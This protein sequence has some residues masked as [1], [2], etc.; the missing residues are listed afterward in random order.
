M[1]DPALDPAAAG[2][3]L[4]AD[5]D[6][7]AG[8]TTGT[9]DNRDPFDPSKVDA[10]LLDPEALAGKSESEIA[11]LMGVG[12]YD[13]SVTA[14]PDGDATMHELSRRADEA[15]IAAAAAPAAA[16]PKVE[17]AAVPAAATPAPA[18]ADP[19][20]DAAALA[21]VAAATSGTAAAETFVETR[22]GKGKIPYGVLQAERRETAR[23]REENARL[24]AAPAPGAAPAQV[25]VPT[26][27][28]AASEIEITA[29]DLAL[30]SEDE[31]KGLR[32]KYPEELVTRMV[33]DNKLAVAAYT[34]QVRDVE[35]RRIDA[36]KTVKN[37]VTDFIDSHPV[38]SIWCAGET[39][40]D[41]AAF[42]RAVIQ[43]QV[44]REL[45]EWQG[46]PWQDRMT[47]AAK[48]TA[49]ILGVAYPGQSPAPT[50]GPQLSLAERANAALAAAA[51]TPKLPTSHSDLPAG[52]PAGSR[53]IDNLALL[54]P[55]QLEAKLEA[56]T[57][58]QRDR[59]L[60]SIG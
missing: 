3:Q 22:D 31:I 14:G 40:A 47:Q 51:A 43:D 9:P 27:E 1:S 4:N 36:E 18:K 35:A 60:A 44:L 30:Y 34:N 19:A 11:A 45:P 32:E 48:D 17:P 7:P 15:A 49:A 2:K 52:T 13:R 20:A 53:E 41:K 28:P 10:L 54:S 58:D 56:M 25:A 50:P 46:R 6:L 39:P 8:E 12:E 57:N 29:D 37:K 42:E 33:R 16:T 38:L 55:T 26:E 59:Y 24:K 23:L 21:A 5:K